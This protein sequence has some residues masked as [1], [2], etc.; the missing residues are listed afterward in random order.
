LAQD[1]PEAKEV[2]GAIISNYWLR[3]LIRFKWW[4]S[5]VN[6]GFGDLSMSLFVPLLEFNQQWAAWIDYEQNLPQLSP[7]LDRRLQREKP[8]LSDLLKEIQQQCQRK[9]LRVP[10]F[11]TVKAHRP[12]LDEAWPAQPP[13]SPRYDPKQ[14]FRLPLELGILTNRRCALFFPIW[15]TRRR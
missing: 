3:L 6:L 13:G 9:G 15:V 5:G 1:S 8:R 14:N 4:I 2:L 12:V 10:N 11:R 7:T